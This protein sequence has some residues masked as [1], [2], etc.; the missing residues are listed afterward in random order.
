MNRFLRLANLFFLSVLSVATVVVAVA[1]DIA[2]TI[3]VETGVTDLPTTTYSGTATLIKTGAGALQWEVPAQP[4]SPLISAAETN[5]SSSISRSGGAGP[6]TFE[7]SVVGHSYQ[8]QYRDSLTSGTWIGY[9][10]PQS[11]S[12]ADLQFAIPYDSSVLKRFYRL[13]IR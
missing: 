3:D 11:G 6:I 13:Q 9:G 12:G 10:Q 5:A 1:Q 8:L 2:T 4:Q 7:T